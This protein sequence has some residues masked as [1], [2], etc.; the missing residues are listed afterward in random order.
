MND[1]A[2][3]LAAK[4]IAEVDRQ[5]LVERGMPTDWIDR[6]LEGLST[7][8][9]AHGAPEEGADRNTWGIGPALWVCFA[10]LC[11]VLIVRAL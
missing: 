6:H 10:A 8:I 4:R 5:D 1:I 2:E 9:A 3:L 11:V 7:E